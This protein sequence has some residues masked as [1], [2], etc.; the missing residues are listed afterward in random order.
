M[1]TTPRWK[2]DKKAYFKNYNKTYNS[3]Y[4]IKNKEAILKQQKQKKYCEICDTYVQ[5]LSI[6]KKTMKHTKNL[7]L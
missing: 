1:I 6:H 5:Q 3:A 4:Y 7:N 2:D